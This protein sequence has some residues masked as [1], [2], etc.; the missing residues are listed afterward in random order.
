MK[1]GVIPTTTTEAMLKYY[2]KRVGESLFFSPGWP[3][4][5]AMTTE[6]EQR[7]TKARV[8]APK[9]LFD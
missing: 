8:W 1:D 2:I 7:A 4:V 5:S 3:S 6:V 9:N